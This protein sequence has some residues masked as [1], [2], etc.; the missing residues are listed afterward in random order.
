MYISFTGFRVCTDLTNDSPQYN[1]GNLQ[2]VA[3]DPWG[4]HVDRVEI[5]DVRSVVI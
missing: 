1:L 5:K 2:E 4:V 3:T